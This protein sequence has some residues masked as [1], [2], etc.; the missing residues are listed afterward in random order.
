MFKSSIKVVFLS[1]KLHSGAFEKDRYNFLILIINYFE[2]VK[3]ICQRV[4]DSGNVY[5]KY[6]TY[7]D[8]CS[9]VFL[10]MKK[11]YNEKYN[12]LDFSQILALRPKD[13]VQ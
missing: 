3:N 13:E 2:P 12:E 7:V 11:A 1:I 4:L 8:N 5:L 6:R 9:S 10:L